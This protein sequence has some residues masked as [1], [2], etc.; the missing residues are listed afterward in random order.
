MHSFQ[1]L[2]F[3]LSNDSLIRRDVTE[4]RLK[5]FAAEAAVGE[6]ILLL[7]VDA[8][9]RV[10][11]KESDEMIRLCGK[12]NKAKAVA[13]YFNHKVGILA[14]MAPYKSAGQALR[15]IRIALESLVKKRRESLYLIGI[16]KVVFEVLQEEAVMPPSGTAMGGIDIDVIKR[17]KELL[18]AGKPI[19]E[20]EMLRSAFVGSSEASSIIR[21]M[22]LRASETEIPVLI[23]G[24][25]GTG[26]E[27]IARQIHNQSNRK[28]GPF[29]VV[30]CGAISENLFESELFGHLKGSFTGALN[31]KNG[32]WTV[33]DRGT[34]FLDEIGDLSLAHQ[35]KVLRALDQSGYLPVGSTVVKKS[36]ARILVATNRNLEEMVEQGTFRED[37]FYR[38]FA[39]SI[40][41][42]A[43]RQHP[44]DLPELAQHFWKKVNVAYPPAPL[45]SNVLDE[46]KVWAWP[47]NARELKGF[48]S[49]VY[50][51]TRRK[52]VTVR[53]VRNVYKE[54][55]LSLPSSGKR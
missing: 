13:L 48:L 37:L 12:K 46:M 8:E 44:E 22:V 27:I 47:G 40:K 3:R 39:F 28:G 7:F 35:V 5:A 25:S 2:D 43:L 11:L 17:Q 1:S 9:L 42:F 53:V 19:D 31:D 20:P 41:T 32:L 45:S 55:H 14:L 21:G 10:L 18:A 38:L 54:R 50:V 4:T 16:P 52:Q 49:H 23:Q 24:E 51:F 29:I 30:N 6:P 33:A 26:K 15:S 36:D 34:L